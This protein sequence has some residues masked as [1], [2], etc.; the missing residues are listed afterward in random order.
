MKILVP[1]EQAPR[2]LGISRVLVRKAPLAWT[3]RTC[4]ELHRPRKPN[5]TGH[6]FWSSFSDV[7]KGNLKRLR[8]ELQPAKARICLRAV[9]A[10]LRLRGKPGRDPQETT[11]YLPFC[12]RRSADQDRWH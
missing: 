6:R 12:R 9:R 4:H 10:G 1:P 8:D 2:L 7:G 11:S 3:P 5:P